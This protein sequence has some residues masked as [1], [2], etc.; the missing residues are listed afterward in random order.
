MQGSLDL[1]EFTAA[2]RKQGHISSKTASEREVQVLFDMVD[3][4]KSGQLSLSEWYLF[5]GLTKDGEPKDGGASPKS[6]PRSAGKPSPQASPR[7]SDGEGGAGEKGK[8]KGKGEPKPKAKP[9]PKDKGA[10]GTPKY[11]STG[12][13]SCKQLTQAQKSWAR[14]QTP[15]DSATGK[16]LCWGAS[17]HSGC[18][19]TAK[20]C[21]F[22]HRPIRPDGQHWCLVFEMN[23]RG[24]NKAKP[25]IPVAKIDDRDAGVDLVVDEHEL[26]VVVALR[27]GERRVVGVSPEIG[28]PARESLF[29]DLVADSVSPALPGLRRKDRDRPEQTH[30]REPDDEDLAGVP[31]RG[32]HQILVFL[33]ARQVRLRRGDQF[34]GPESKNRFFIFPFL[35]FA[36]FMKFRFFENFRSIRVFGTAGALYKSVGDGGRP[37]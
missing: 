29:E 24:G 5:L 8:A 3:L 4:D 20:E 1:R 14:K 31:A 23:L 33:P 10:K 25:A 9:E 32:E 27:L 22:S 11:P 21:R 36:I 19:Y 6:S 13:A 26:A 2:V 28:L 17:C 35:R 18:P 15:I 30:A 7:S 12:V 34:L 37:I 16:S